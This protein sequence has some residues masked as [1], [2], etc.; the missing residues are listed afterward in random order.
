MFTPDGTLSDLYR[1]SI[2][3]P[4]GETNPFAAV[5]PGFGEYLRGTT[6]SIQLDRGDAP[7]LFTVDGSGGASLKFGVLVC[8]ESCFGQLGRGYARDGADFLVSATDD[9]WSL[10]SV[11]M[12]QHAVM[13]VFRAVETRTPVLRV[14]NGGLSC[15]VDERGRYA[16]SLPLFS[17][18]AMTS[19]L[20]LLR[21]RPVTLYVRAGDWLVPFSIA[22]LLAALWILLR[23]S[24]GRGGI[25]PTC[26]GL[27]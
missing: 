25:T 20:Y 18:G 1:K 24:R 7:H 14:S 23:A 17:M 19:K 5:F 2:L 22:V 9:S 12:Y 15:Y 6:A 16:T 13:S 21:A 4:F 26:R 27:P 8:F 11:A 3:V 10:S